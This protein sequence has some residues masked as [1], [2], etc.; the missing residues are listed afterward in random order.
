MCAGCTTK[1][2]VVCVC[3]V[4]VS[5]L[6]FRGIHPPCWPWPCVVVASTRS[7]GQHGLLSCVEGSWKQQHST[8]QCMHARPIAAR[9]PAQLTGPACNWAQDWVLS[10]CA[11]DVCVVCVCEQGA[12]R[13]PHCVYVC[14]MYVGVDCSC[15]FD[16]LTPVNCSLVLVGRVCPGESV[17]DSCVVC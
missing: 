17:S 10:H 6:L 8:V 13:T 14:D 3:C 1:V 7:W 5:L 16:L 15:L 4:C 12:A 11:H 2:W 9:V